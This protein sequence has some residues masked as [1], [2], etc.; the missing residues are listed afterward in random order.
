M[1]ASS[2]VQSFDI[3]KRGK[4]IRSHS[5]PGSLRAEEAMGCSGTVMARLN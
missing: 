1:T 3:W 2:E 5:A 4:V